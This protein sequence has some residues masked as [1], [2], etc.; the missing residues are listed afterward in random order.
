M[1]IASV[2]FD[3]SPIEAICRESGIPIDPF[4]DSPEDNLGQRPALKMRNV[5]FFAIIFFYLLSHV[6]MRQA[7]ANNIL[8][9]SVKAAKQFEQ[10]L[11]TASPNARNL[12]SYI[13]VSS[14]DQHLIVNAKR[15]FVNL[16][17]EQI[18]AISKSIYDLWIGTKYV[19]EQN[20]GKWIEVRF[21][22]DR[23]L[24]SMPVKTIR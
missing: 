4:R 20:W 9:Q 14:K 12:I 19:R 1:Q 2:E 5:I 22:D 23:A 16:P 21:W 15:S 7:I 11:F 10:L 13:D 3:W 8:Q 18:D 24:K 17:K 6:P